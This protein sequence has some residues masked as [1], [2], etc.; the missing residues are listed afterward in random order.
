MTRLMQRLTLLVTFAFTAMS[1]SSLL[2]NIRRD[3][4]DPTAWDAPTVGGRWAERGLLDGGGSRGPASEGRAAQQSWI[5]PEQRDVNTRDTQR[6]PAAGAASDGSMAYSSNPVNPPDSQSVYKNGMRATRADFV[7]DSQNEGSLWASDGQ[8]NY[9]FTKNKVRG[10]GDIITIVME[11]DLVQ[12]TGTEITR[13]LNVREREYELALAQAR[14]QNEATAKDENGQP[15][16]ADTVTTTAAAPERQPASADAAAAAGVRKATWAD[17]DVL[18]SLD[19]KE[20]ATMMGEI[21]E[22]FPNGNYKVRATKRVRYNNSIRL[23]TLLGVAKGSDI[24]DND[25]IKSGKL[26]E[27]RL[28]VLR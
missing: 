12:D 27:Y 16:N 3:I 26:Y 8:T 6:G 28:E 1:C 22:R 25:T 15:L 11:K 10:V 7:D 17:V 2:S 20:G 14:I 19:L 9:Y 18:K 24:D 4:D 13:T 21:L 5:S 23:V